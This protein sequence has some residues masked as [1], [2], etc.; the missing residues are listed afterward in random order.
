MSSDPAQVFVLYYWCQIYKLFIK[1]FL[2]FTTSVRKCLLYFQLQTLI[3]SY[4]RFFFNGFTWKALLHLLKLWHKYFNKNNRCLIIYFYS[5]LFFY[6]CQI[7]RVQRLY[8]PRQSLLFHQELLVL[9]YL[10]WILHLFLTIRYYY[11]FFS[12]YRKSKKT[13][14]TL[15]R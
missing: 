15:Q 7:Q 8:T 13:I 9:L 12:I 5:C 10:L 4:R 11:Y 3:M 6:R 1:P 2:R 14:G